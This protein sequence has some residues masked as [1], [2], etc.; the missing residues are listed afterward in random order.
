MPVLVRYKIG[1]D[2]TEEQYKKWL[3]QLTWWVSSRMPNIED[4]P[5]YAEKVIKAGL[6][7]TKIDGKIWH[8][9]SKDFYKRIKQLAGYDLQLSIGVREPVRRNYANP[10]HTAGKTTELPPL[11]LEAAMELRQSYIK[12]LIQKYPHLDT[13]V[14]KPKV[15]E[16]AETVIKSRMISSEFLTSRGSTLERLSKVRESLHKQI[17]ELMEF[18]EISPKQRLTKTL[19]AKNSDVGSIVA[20]LESYGDTWKEFE[21]IDSLRELLQLYKMLKS[22]RPDGSPQ[23]NDWEL[24]HMTRNRP[25]TFVC[26]CG[27]SYSL[28]G[29]FTADEIE[30]ALLQAQTVYGYGLEDISSKLIDSGTLPAVVTIDFESFDEPIKNEFITDPDSEV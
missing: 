3:E 25:I 10:V 20:R 6:N 19:G 8:G 16:L 24:W 29:G 2:F 7:G 22:T 26:R 21:K 13:P 1:V 5:A 15:E 28:L 12:E 27:E 17:G 18:L 23:L 14:Y 30:Q 4:P 11:N 9:I